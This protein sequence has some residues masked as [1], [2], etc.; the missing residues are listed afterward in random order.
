M[1]VC[2]ELV[3]EAAT[4]RHWSPS[5]LSLG[6]VKAC[7]IYSKMWKTVQAFEKFKDFRNT[8]IGNKAAPNCY[9]NLFSAGWHRRQCV[10]R[11]FLLCYDYVLNAIV[12]CRPVPRNVLW[13]LGV[14]CKPFG[15][16]QISQ[17]SIKV[18]CK[19][20]WK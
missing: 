20:Y 13:V 10:V 8:E 5:G 16:K 7:E 14:F 12:E 9:P 4:K 6:S 3:W 11:T 1:G 15:F 2:A 19:C 17:V 18:L